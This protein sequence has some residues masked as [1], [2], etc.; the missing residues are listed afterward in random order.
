VL[1]WAEFF[2]WEAGKSV[3]LAT[4]LATG[5]SD[6]PGQRGAHP[7]QQAGP[8]VPQGKQPSLNFL[9]K[10]RNIFRCEYYLTLC[11]GSRSSV[12]FLPLD[13]ES[14]AFLAPGS[15][16]GKKSG[17][18]SG[19]NIPDHISESLEILF[20]GHEPIYFIENKEKTLRASYDRGT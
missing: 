5:G 15:G 14:G 16:I 18:G 6:G 17:S 12:P 2:L 13:P 10:F 20:S 3:E 4:P 1:W 9:L 19:I 11:C 8:G 7:G